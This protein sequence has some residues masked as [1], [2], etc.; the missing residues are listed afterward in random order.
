MKEKLILG[1]LISM[2]GVGFAVNLLSNPSFE[3][4]SFNYTSNVFNTAISNGVW[5]NTTETLRLASPGGCYG[6]SYCMVI[7]KTSVSANK[8]FEQI[9]SF[10]PGNYTRMNVS[11]WAKKFGLNPANSTALY[12]MFLNPSK[13]VISF[14]STSFTPGDSWAQIRINGGSIPANTSYV[15]I[16]VTT[17]TTGMQSGVFDYAEL[18]PYN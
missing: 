17:L 6:G 13:G 7:N 3:T 5:A 12:M 8:G 18:T 10:T 4:N 16:I 15:Q 14:Y 2:M 1:L 11:I 9:I